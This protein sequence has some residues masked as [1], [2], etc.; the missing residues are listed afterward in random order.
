MPKDS[1]DASTLPHGNNNG[2]LKRGDACL[3]CRKRRIKCTAERP[4]CH[5]CSKAGKTCV[6]D[7]GKP[8]SKIKQ[9]EERVSELQSMLQAGMRPP[10]SAGGAGIDASVNTFPSASQQAPT[11]FGQ[12]NALPGFEVLG[13]GGNASGDMGSFNFTPQTGYGNAGT[14]FATPG[15]FN[16]VNMSM[17]PEPFNP[18]RMDLEAVAGFD[19]TTLDPSINNLV[20][21]FQATPGPLPGGSIPQL[22]EE[23][24]GSFHPYEG[25]G[26]AAL[27]YSTHRS[28][29][30]DGLQSHQVS[31]TGVSEL[32]TLQ[33]RDRSA[34]DPSP[35][36]R[37]TDSL[38][39]HSS[40]SF[41][42]QPQ[43]WRKPSAEEVLD[44]DTLVG[45]WYDPTD[46]PKVARDYL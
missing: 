29:E 7:V 16:N 8:V 41:G 31:A 2:P 22:T 21:S 25:D 39:T 12:A 3:Q 23:N 38:P 15:Q 13:L 24:R 40:S 10:S 4:A 43:S 42:A 45:G 32:P 20:S 11:S 26:T 35:E 5:N 36:S 34:G 37:A 33:F 17:V 18:S 27:G 28:P 1:T 14:H 44:C 19:W 6:Y 46:L 9:L 30:S